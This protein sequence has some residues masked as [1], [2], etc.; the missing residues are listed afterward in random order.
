MNVQTRH[1]Y[2][3]EIDL[4]T[5]TAPARVVRMV[6]QGKRVLEIGAGP[7][8][9]TRL[10]R[11]ASQCRVT[12]VEIDS[13]AI[14]ILTPFCERV[15]QADLNDS[16]W[17]MVLQDDGHFEVVVVADVL[18]HLYDPWSSLKLMKELIGNGGYMVV[19]LPHA[20]HSALLACLLEEDFEYRD[21]GLLDRTHIRFF[22]MKNIQSLFEGAGLKIVEVQFVVVRPEM[23]EFAERWL[24][25]PRRVR[26]ALAVSKFSLVY[27]V[28]LKAV[29][30]DSTSEPSLSLL[31]VPVCVPPPVTQPESLWIR[32]RS[33]LSPEIRRKLRGIAVRL[34]IRKR[35]GQ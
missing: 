35:Q 30:S 29:P 1:K 7:G 2:E 23:T 16:A 21:W 11:D 10:M 28:V 27:Q 26:R 6:G 20:G 22:G 19:S 4:N 25:I 5:D 15:Y 18:E 13:E 24:R 14:K 34:G 32:V 17:P 8:S 33:H 3:R 9:I 12:A 31:S